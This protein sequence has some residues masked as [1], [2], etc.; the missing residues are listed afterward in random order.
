ME[1]PDQKQEA[2]SR[3]VCLLMWNDMSEALGERTKIITLFSALTFRSVDIVESDK[4][5][6][7]IT[8]FSS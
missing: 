8:R 4:K 3:P 5:N 2:V 7:V 6:K 1:K